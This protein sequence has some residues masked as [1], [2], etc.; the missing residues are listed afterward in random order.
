[1]GKSIN[2]FYFLKRNS[3]S[4]SRDLGDEQGCHAAI[5]N[6]EKLIQQALSVV[7]IDST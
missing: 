2:L 6:V 3:F 5:W 1:M 7:S 4:R